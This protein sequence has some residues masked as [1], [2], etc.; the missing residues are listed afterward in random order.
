M[1]VL[2]AKLKLSSARSMTWIIRRSKNR[3]PLPS[4][5]LIVYSAVLLVTQNLRQIVE[6][7]YI[8]REKIEV[9]WGRWVLTVRWCRFWCEACFSRLGGISCPEYSIV[10]VKNWYFLNLS[11]A[12]GFLSNVNTLRAWS[13]CCSGDLVTIT[14]SSGILKHNA[15]LLMTV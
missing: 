11:F 14:M 5:C 4:I 6:K 12:P 10:S 9:T 13:V 15:I 3:V 8:L 1:P 2:V 7:T